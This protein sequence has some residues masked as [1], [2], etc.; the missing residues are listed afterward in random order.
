MSERSAKKG[1]IQVFIAGIFWGTT[2]LFMQLLAGLGASN[3]FISFLRVGTASLIMI[4]FVWLNCGGAKAFR[5]D[6]STLF[7]CATMGFTAHTLF[8]LCYTEA[9]GSV[10]MAT[11]ALLLYTSLIFLCVLSRIIFNEPITKHKIAA[12]AINI[13]GCTLAVT[14]GDLAS[15]SFIIYGILMGLLAALSYCTVP[16]FGKITTGN[17]HPFVVTFYNFMFGTLFL[18]PFLGK[19]PL[20]QGTLSAGIILLGIGA[21]LVSAVVPYMFFMTG[22][23]KPVEA[24]KVNV[25]ASMEIVV[26]TLIGVSVFSEYFNLW[27]LAG[28]VLVF[29]SILVMNMT[30]KKEAALEQDRVK[31]E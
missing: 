6:R 21:G 11:S 27:K 24:S 25:I 4:P 30:P 28:M 9:V 22:L 8:N 3:A 12:L 20:V 23:S 14:G 1:Y 26:A 18:L 31:Y 7:L 10:G 29:I 17:T 2:G 5:I 16:I 19:E 13:I 15:L